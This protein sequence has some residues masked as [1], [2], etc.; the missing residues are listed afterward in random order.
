MRKRSG[1]TLIEIIVT[2]VVIGIAAAAL[3]SIFSNLIR[4]SADPMIQ[5]Q[6]TT[7]A[8]AYLEEI[9]LKAFDDPQVAETGAAE[10]GETRATYDD[11]Q[12]Y[13]SADTVV[14]DQNGNAITPQFDA[15]NINIVVAGDTLNTVAA[16]RIDVTVSHA[17]VAG[18]TLSAYRTDY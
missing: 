18:I 3:L 5:Q 2:L 4:G 15:Y 1:F 16:M 10:A 11:V 14:R 13:N 9:M 6:A 12:D 7:I 17:A 8:E